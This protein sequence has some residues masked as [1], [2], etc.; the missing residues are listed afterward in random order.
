MKPQRTLRKNSSSAHSDCLYYSTLTKINYYVLNVCLGWNFRYYFE[1]LL[2][3]AFIHILFRYCDQPCDQVK[4]PAIRR[5]FRSLI[6]LFRYMPLDPLT[7]RGL[8]CTKPVKG[9]EWRSYESQNVFSE[10]PFSVRSVV[11]LISSLWTIS[12]IIGYAPSSS[13]MSRSA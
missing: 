7:K 8:R 5:A 12:W 2:S 1:Q 10:Q 6:I 11:L 13:F 9:T 4:L 3:A